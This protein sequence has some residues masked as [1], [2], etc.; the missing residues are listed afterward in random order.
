MFQYTVVKDLC[1][2][3]VIKRRISEEF[4]L[5]FRECKNIVIPLPVGV[6]SLEEKNLEKYFEI[7]VSKDFDHRRIYILRKEESKLCLIY[8]IFLDG[9]EKSKLKQAFLIC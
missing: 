6:E 5:F 9:I 8:E 3:S 7:L 2:G 1:G 4:F